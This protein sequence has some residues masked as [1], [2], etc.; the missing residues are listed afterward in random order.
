M[1][2]LTGACCFGGFIIL[3]VPN[4]IEHG[5]KSTRYDPSSPSNEER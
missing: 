5:N 3:F 2:L 1:T 4:Q